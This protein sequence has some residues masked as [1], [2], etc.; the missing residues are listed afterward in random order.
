MEGHAIAGVSR[1]GRMRKISSKLIDLPHNK[2]KTTKPKIDVSVCKSP[3]LKLKF[4]V[5]PFVGFEPR[6][7]NEL[8]SE[9]STD[10]SSSVGELEE[11]NIM[12]T[13]PSG[14][15]STVCTVNRKMD[16]K[17]K[18]NHPIWSSVNSTKCLNAEGWN[19]ILS[20]RPPIN[21]VDVH[22]NAMMTTNSRN[23]QNFH[24]GPTKLIRKNWVHDLIAVPLEWKKRFSWNEKRHWRMPKLKRILCHILLTPLNG[25]LM[26]QLYHHRRLVERDL[27]MSW[28]HP[29]K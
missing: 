8:L 25:C 23:A 6:T 29:L 26:R 5:D 10:T 9:D 27:L 1:F 22:V 13:S 24:C 20:N 21:L 3:K 16:E 7:F 28:H 12:T 19:N 18:I 4:F 14:I 15:I 11:S 17:K 2:Q